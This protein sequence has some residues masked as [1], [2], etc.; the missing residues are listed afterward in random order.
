MAKSSR[1]VDFDDVCPSQMAQVSHRG[2]ECAG[3]GRARAVCLCGCLCV[4]ASVLCVGVLV[5]RIV[6][7]HL[8]MFIII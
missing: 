4:C 7:V 2:G 1:D 3:E 8:V 5:F 6:W